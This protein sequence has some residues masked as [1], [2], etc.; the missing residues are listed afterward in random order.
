MRRV[1]GVIMVL[2]LLF[3]FVGCTNEPAVPKQ[4]EPAKP[5]PV[6]TP[7]PTP[8]APSLPESPLTGVGYEPARLNRRPI[9]VMI[10]NFVRARPQSGLSRASVVYEM[11]TEGGIT[12]FL[13]LFLENEVNQIGP[14][15][16]SR[17]YFAYVAAGH[18]AV[19]AHV[20]ATAQ[21]YAEIQQLKI[22]NLDD[23]TDRNVFWRAQ[24]RSAPH[25]LY[26]ST[27][28]MR[29]AMVERRLERPITVEP[30]FSFTD[31]PIPGTPATMVTVPYAGGPAYTVKYAYD[32]KTKTYKRFMGQEPH[33]DAIDGRQIECR[34]VVVLYINSWV[35]PDDPDRRLEMD[36]VGSGVGVVF[37]DGNFRDIKWSKTSK[38]SRF[39]LTEM[40]GK[41]AVAPRGTIW[42]QIV[43]LDTEITIE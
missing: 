30:L 21:G 25:N 9:A 4:K 40:D 17:H 23:M 13:A 11:L 31:N 1:L 33:T 7:A 38:T 32:D 12:R 27:A 34:T 8:P 3:L 15:R 20:G 35:I 42:V 19:Y 39:V 29:S 10:D 22:A 24:G 37:S 18:D 28:N 5:T 14:V 26:T 6:P 16:S 43:P 41:P 36:I 2:A